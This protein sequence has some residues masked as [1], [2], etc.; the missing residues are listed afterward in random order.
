MCRKL[1][2]FWAALVAAIAW[3]AF[4]I[5]GKRV[6]FFSMATAAPNK[7]VAPARKMS[8]ILP[9]L[10]DCCWSGLAKLVA[11]WGGTVCGGNLSWRAFQF[12]CGSF[13]LSTRQEHIHMSQVE[14][15]TCISHLYSSC[16]WECTTKADQGCCSYSCCLLLPR[17]AV[18]ILQ[19]HSW[20]NKEYIALGGSNDPCLQIVQTPTCTVEG[21]HLPVENQSAYYSMRPL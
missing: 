3:L 11:S 12:Q 6:E 9:L 8:Q 4:A 2:T 17:A 10:T 20:L 1:L 18:R 5:A 7:P 21:A 14:V 19:E 15:V 13:A 16:R